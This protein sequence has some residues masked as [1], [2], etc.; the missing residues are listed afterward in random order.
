MWY[1]AVGY[2]VTLILSLLTVSLAAEAQPPG[3]IYRIGYLA[4]GTQL[5]TPFREALR[6]FGYVEGQNVVIEGRF[7]GQELDHLPH[8]AAEL[9]QLKVDVIVTVSSYARR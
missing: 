9:V 6:Q 7:A 4:P 3:K 1:S 2:L 8:L 5:P